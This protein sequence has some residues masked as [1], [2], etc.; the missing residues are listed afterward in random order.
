M[1]RGQTM[2][3]KYFNWLYWCINLGSLFS[4]SFLAYYQQNHSFFIGYLIPFSILILSFVI[5]L[6][7]SACYIKQKA[8][9]SVLS[10]I[11]RVLIEAF[12]SNR[13][14]KNQF[15]QQQRERA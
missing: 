6:C 10:N 8:E 1:S 7:G 2:I 14:H 3:F 9:V 4:F 12:K 5:F 13:R 11:F 15:R